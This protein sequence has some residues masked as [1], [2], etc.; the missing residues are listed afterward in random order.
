MR[1]HPKRQFSRGIREAPLLSGNPGCW[2]ITTYPL[3]SVCKRILLS[4][5]FA[6]SSSISSSRWWFQS[7]F[8]FH[9][10]L[11]RWFPCWRKFFNWA[12]QPPTSHV[13]FLTYSWFAPWKFWDS[14]LTRRHLRH[15]SNL[16]LKL[17]QIRIF[18][19]FGC[20]SENSR[21]TRRAFSFLKDGWKWYW[22]HVIWFSE[23]CFYMKLLP[24]CSKTCSDFQWFTST[25]SWSQK[26]HLKLGNF[27]FQDPKIPEVC[28][29]HGFWPCAQQKVESPFPPV[30]SHHSLPQLFPKPYLFLIISQYKIYIYIHIFPPFS[31]GVKIMDRKSLTDVLRTRFWVVGRGCHGVSLRAM[32]MDTWWWKNREATKNGRKKWQK[33]MFWCWKKSWQICRLLGGLKFTSYIHPSLMGLSL[34]QRFS[35]YESR[36]FWMVSAW[37]RERRQ[38]HKHKFMEIPLKEMKRMHA[39][40]EFTYITL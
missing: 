29:V 16:A 12:A 39:A 24:E 27:L 9:H 15:N 11:G 6:C 22:C 17:G 8:K 28:S 4:Y 7:F 21:K 3:E 1:A 5:K 33:A 34:N 14:L 37:E 35:L 36:W 40:D 25:W 19:A 30:F 23:A 13:Y 18:M 10:S 32:G 31:G 2:N 26:A 38:T 20:V